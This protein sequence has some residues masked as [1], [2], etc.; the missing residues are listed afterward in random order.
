MLELSIEN[1]RLGL[2]A[3]ANWLA[4]CHFRSGRYRQ[5]TNINLGRLNYFLDFGAVSTPYITLHGYFM[6][7]R[8]D[9]AQQWFSEYLGRSGRK[10]FEKDARVRLA[11]YFMQNNCGCCTLTSRSL[12]DIPL[13]TISPAYQSAVSYGLLGN[14]TRKITILRQALK[15]N[16]NAE[17]YTQCLFEL[18]RTLVQRGAD[19]DAAECFLTL[20]GHDA[21]STY[22]TKSMRELAMINANN[23]KY[24]KAIEYYK[25]IIEGMPLSPEVPNA[26]SGMESVYQTINQPEEYFASRNSRD[27]GY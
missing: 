22:F 2:E 14:D 19:D 9:R 20:I 27:V 3:L 24:N 1:G 13:Q 15:I 6:W 17:L 11:L 23:G 26:I 5:S 10:Q 12:T 16:R 25:N 7:G 4:E 21:D 18:G 8:F